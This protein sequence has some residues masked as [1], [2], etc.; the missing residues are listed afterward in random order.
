MPHKTERN[1]K[2]P[3]VAKPEPDKDGI[4]EFDY[5]IYEK[6]IPMARCIFI[7]HTESRQS[8]NIT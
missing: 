7:L 4:V 1:K 3:V 8:T 2:I 6:I 5:S